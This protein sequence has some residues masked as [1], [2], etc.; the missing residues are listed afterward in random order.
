MAESDWRVT[1][2]EVEAIIDYDDTIE[3]DPF[4]EVANQLVTELCTDSDYADSRLTEIERW[5]SAH[6]YHIRDQ[7]VSAE[8]AGE[9][10]VNYQYKV[11]LHFNQT[12]YG[13]MA[14]L[15]DTAGNLAQLNKRIKDGEASQALLGWLGIDYNDEEVSPYY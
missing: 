13:Q 15:L 3:L 6:F 11:D 2:A 4:I 9:V 5:L 7:H 14:L 10:G 1:E 12:K 8:R